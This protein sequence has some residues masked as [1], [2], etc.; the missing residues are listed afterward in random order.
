MQQPYG[1]PLRHL[2][3]TRFANIAQP[4][5]GAAVVH[6]VAAQSIRRMIERSEGMP[7][8]GLVYRLR[9]SSRSREPV[10]D[11]LLVDV[12]AKLLD[13]RDERRSAE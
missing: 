7:V 13:G 4:M 9:H 6:G 8:V 2:V 10:D 12:E 5:I 11:D 1:A 3:W